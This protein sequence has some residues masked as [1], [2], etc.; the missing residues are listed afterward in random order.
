MT[1]IPRASSLGQKQTP[2]DQAWS[3]PLFRRRSRGC[4]LGGGEA[5]APQPLQEEHTDGKNLT[6]LTQWPVTVP[7]CGSDEGSARRTTPGTLA[8]RGTGRCKFMVTMS[9]L[10]QW[11]PG[12]TKDR[13]DGGF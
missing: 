8:S 13:H 1:D 7:A 6:P 4:G 12:N 3:L 2:R 5:P 11:T 10:H 9:R